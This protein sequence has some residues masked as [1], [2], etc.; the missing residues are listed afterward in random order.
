MSLSLDSHD[1]QF[2]IVITDNLTNEPHFLKTN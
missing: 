2:N 1:I